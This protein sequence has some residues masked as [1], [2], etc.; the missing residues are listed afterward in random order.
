MT[1]GS[2]MDYWL[3]RELGQ[4]DAICRNYWLDKYAHQAKYRFAVTHVAMNGWDVKA[5]NRLRIFDDTCSPYWQLKQV[6]QCLVNYGASYPDLEVLR[7][8]L[9]EWYTW[10]RL[11]KG[12]L[13]RWPY[14]SSIALI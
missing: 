4:Q 5:L 11:R 9:I 12:D 2:F 1:W 7:V 10:D 14:R 13:T 6:A 8:R 3:M